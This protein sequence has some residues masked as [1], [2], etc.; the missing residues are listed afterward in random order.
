MGKEFLPVFE[1]WADSYDLTVSRKDNEYQEYFH[2]YDEIL[3]M[4]TARS[5]GTVLEFGVGTGNLTKK[6]VSK[7]LDVIGIDPSNA[8][9]SKAKEKIPELEILDGD[10]DRYP[11]FDIAINSIVSTYAFHHL[12]D[13][14]KGIS[15][16]KFYETLSPG[17]KVIFA[18]VMFE[19]KEAYY[20]AISEAKENEYHNVLRDLQEEYYSTLEVMKKLFLLNNFEI[21]FIQCNRY[22]WL[23]EATKK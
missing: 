3:D 8:M 11:D 5:F 17:G 20:Q 21:S 2:N 19:N 15:I 22:V 1:G 12:T 18:D 13:E 6:L 16:K 7:G 23:L 4:V 10:F 14:D 9:R